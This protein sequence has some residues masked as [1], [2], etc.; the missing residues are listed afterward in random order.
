[1]R[2]LPQNGQYY[3]RL[4]AKL[5]EQES[6]IEKLQA[7]R[8]ELTSRRDASRKELDDYLDTLNTD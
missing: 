8:K 1:M 7:E 5:N 2:I 3:D 4:L 6:T